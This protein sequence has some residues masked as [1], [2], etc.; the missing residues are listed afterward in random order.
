MRLKGDIDMDT[1]GADYIYMYSRSRSGM[2]EFLLEA[3]GGSPE[4]LDLHGAT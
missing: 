3:P 2:F 1:T 4:K